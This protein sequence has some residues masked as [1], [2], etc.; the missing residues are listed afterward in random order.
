MAHWNAFNKRSWEHVFL[1]ANDLLDDNRCLVHLQSSDDASAMEFFSFAWGSKE[2]ILGKKYTCISN[3]L[4]HT[5]S[6]KVITKIP[7]N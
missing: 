4:M 7:P 3:I 6:G 1:M 5:K 2:S